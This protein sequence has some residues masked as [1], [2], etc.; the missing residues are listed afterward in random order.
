VCETDERTVFL[1]DMTRNLMQHFAD[2]PLSEDGD[3][4]A[5]PASVILMAWT[6]DKD[7]VTGYILF[8]AS[9]AAA[10]CNGAVILADGGRMTFM[11]ATC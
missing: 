9:R 2:G 6:G 7:D 8:M 5:V 10:Y 3:A 1:S 4:V 11:S